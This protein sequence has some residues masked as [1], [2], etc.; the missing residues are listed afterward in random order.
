MTAQLRAA[1]R[2]LGLLITDL[3]LCEAIVHFIRLRL[4][5]VRMSVVAKFGGYRQEFRAGIKY[6][7]CRLLIG[8]AEVQLAHVAD[9]LVVDEGELLDLV[10]LKEQIAGRLLIVPFALELND[11]FVGLL[12]PRP[13]L[14]GAELGEILSVQRGLIDQV[15]SFLKFD[16]V[17]R[18]RDAPLEI[19]TKVF[20]GDDAQ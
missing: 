9:V 4:A 5:S 11:L 8:R 12:G 10:E 20:S 13:L 14:H 19:D 6:D 18:R 3:H 1:V 17:P 2:D 7:R 16:G 15:L